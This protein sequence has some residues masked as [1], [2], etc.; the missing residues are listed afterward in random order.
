MFLLK[1]ENFE[2]NSIWSHGELEFLCALANSS[3]EF[4]TLWSLG[5]DVKWHLSSRFS[6]R[7]SCVRKG[8]RRCS[9]LTWP[10]SMV[11]PRWLRALC[12]TLRNMDFNLSSPMFL[13]LQNLLVIDGLFNQRLCLLGTWYSC[14]VLNSPWAVD[15]VRV[16]EGSGTD[17]NFCG[18]L[19][20]LPCKKWEEHFHS[21]NPLQLKLCFSLFASALFLVADFSFSSLPLHISILCLFFH[22]S[23]FTFLFSLLFCAGTALLCPLFSI[24]HAVEL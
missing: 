5:W 22:L 15:N 8:S 1:Y 14:H 13:Y 2:E 12:V 19:S 6:R 3:V 4:Q 9:P 18:S 23:F 21:L 10:W 7:G 24:F 16:S 20:G 11:G 17:T